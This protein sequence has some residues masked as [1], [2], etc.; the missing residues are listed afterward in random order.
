[1][2]HVICFSHRRQLQLHG[3]LASL[4]HYLTAWDQ[5]S[6]VYPKQDYKTVRDAFG[7]V[8]FLGENPDFNATLKYVMSTV[9][10]PFVMFGCDDM[11]FTRSV[12]VEEICGQLDT[13]P[14]IL[15][16]STRLH[17]KLPHA[18]MSTLWEWPKYPPEWYWRYPFDLSGS[19]Y[20]TECIKNLLANIGHQKSP[21]TFESKGVLF[22]VECLG[23]NYPLLSRGEL[24]SCIIQQVNNVQTTVPINEAH[25]KE[26]HA[27]E[28]LEE[29]YKSGKRLDWKKAAGA[30]GDH[31]WTNDFWSVT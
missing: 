8:V 19:I 5:V 4:Y 28:R 31:V 27:P 17:G 30:C 24:P 18:P 15:G 13:H 23:K 10:Q 16:Y 14:T 12:D 29:L 26:E 20:R 7:G 21:N 3:Y 6:V 25:Y 1:M 9:H 11:V 2:L 22:M